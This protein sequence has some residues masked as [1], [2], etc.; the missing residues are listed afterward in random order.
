M[1]ECSQCGNAYHAPLEITRNGETFHFDCFE[2]A[3]HKLAPE[4]P[5]CGV[6]I[7]G[8]GVESESG[9]IYC[10]DPCAQSRGATEARA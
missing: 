9:V 10:C 5:A 6:K 4:C 7:I 2:C 3:I 1:I 8:H